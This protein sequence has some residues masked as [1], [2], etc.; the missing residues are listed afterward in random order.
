MRHGL[1]GCLIVM[2]LTGAAKAAT[3]SE[4]MSDYRAHLDQAIIDYYMYPDQAQGADA[5]QPP[6]ALMD[7][8]DPSLARLIRQAASSADQDVPTAIATIRARLQQ[9][10]TLENYVID[11]Q[12]SG[13]GVKVNPRY[14]I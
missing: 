9:A 2:M 6:E 1:I 10:C 12:P 8:I 3:P 4:M 14:L 11:T 5:V 13:G 7:A